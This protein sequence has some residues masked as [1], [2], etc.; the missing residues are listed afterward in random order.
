[1]SR[2]ALETFLQFGQQLDQLLIVLMVGA[3]ALAVIGARRVRTIPAAPG[4]VST[5]FI[6][7]LVGLALLARLPLLTQSPWY[8]ET[9]TARMASIDWA[10]FPAALAGDVHPPGYYILA[11]LAVELLGESDAAI[12]LPALAGGLALIPL[13]ARLAWSFTGDRRVALA[14]AA[15]V[16]ALPASM[17]YSAE[18]RYPSM[19][20]AAVLAAL[21]AYR[22]GR[23]RAFALATGSLIYWHNLGAVYLVLFALAAVLRWR[24]RRWVLAGV[25][26][27]AL[28][29]PWLPS[30]VDQARDVLDGFWL[31][32]TRVPVWHLIS[33]TM[34]QAAAT[35]ALLPVQWGTP[36]LL[37]ALGLWASRDWIRRHPIWLWVA[38]GAPMALW[39]A[40]IWSPVYLARALLAPALLFAIPWAWLLLRTAGRWRWA[41]AAL[42]TI[43][44]LSGNVRQLTRD[45]TEIA[46]VFERCAGADVVYT[47]STNMAVMAAR[48][49]PGLPTF[50]WAG[51]NNLHQVLSTEARLAMNLTM[52]PLARLAGQEVCMVAQLSYYTTDEELSFIEAVEREQAPTIETV[53]ESDL[54]Q[55]AVLRFS[56]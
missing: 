50:T 30:M 8:D 41:S 38:I 36:L 18:A 34:R 28:A 27:L 16:A 51:G 17:Y 3:G 47:T 42:L 45:R 24:S 56:P 13:I 20:A 46:D 53:A 22:E 44:I 21:L 12:R 1:M 48:Y 15:I 39:A 23:P 14:A 35:P 5:F 7:A 6:W 37:S 9:F 11:R 10:S 19:L 52:I 33:M 2:P 43:G 40:Q 32:D 54:F 25:G 31:Q 4:K 29:L 26:S 55:Y 49:S